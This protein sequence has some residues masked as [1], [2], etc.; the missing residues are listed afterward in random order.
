MQKKYNYKLSIIFLI[1][2][3]LC[4]IGLGIYYGSNKQN[5][6][7]DEVLTY[8]LSN[9]TGG[10]ALE[11]PEGEY[12]TP[13]VFDNMMNV[14][15]GEQ[16]HYESV[17]ENQ[18]NDVHPPLYY[19]IIHTVCSFFPETFSMWTGI[20]VN[21]FCAVIITL[22][23]FKIAE[24]FTR[25]TISAVLIAAAWACS[26][27]N[28][29]FIL[30]IRMYMLLIVWC[31]LFVLIHLKNYGEQRNWKFYA[32]LFIATLAGTL[33][34]YYFLIFIF[35]CCA[36]YC[37]SLL[38]KKQW[39]A[40]LCYGTVI[41][42]AGMTAVFIFHGVFKHI[43]MGQ[44]GE[45]SFRN[46][47]NLDNVVER[48]SWF[49]R[50]IN[51]QTFDGYI[52][53][54]VCVCIG[55]IIYCHVRRKDAEDRADKRFVWK[56]FLTSPT[57]LLCVPAIC[58]FFLVSQIAVYQVERYM[59]TI[60]PFIVL[61][62]GV[63]WHYAAVQL[64][65]GKTVAYLG[66]IILI[67]L[68]LHG[69]ATVKMEF[70]YVNDAERMEFARNNR[71]ENVIVVADNEQELPYYAYMEL[72]NYEQFLYIQADNLEIL[73]EKQLNEADSAI[74]YILADEKD[75]IEGE[76]ELLLENCDNHYQPFP[77]D[78]WIYE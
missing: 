78:V 65:N 9:S 23:V 59:I 77:S 56:Q 5:L 57:L 55:V 33:T 31:L 20:A 19:A 63:L 49:A 75:K 43:F 37:L 18:N 16:F 29:N 64:K 40:I 71:K 66:G 51:I 35:F 28:M 32:A 68:S 34:H 12:L 73:K 7:I 60:Y 45:E 70:R 10:I 17:W 41:A 13:A 21:L 36:V 62:I 46:F 14:N 58:Y 53:F 8:A 48:I 38:I 52:P 26:N 25:D 47:F 15:R 54:I 50:K 11:L 1:I 4:E 72:R 24:Y 39:K 44:R 42:G 69:L 27:A 30:F 22:L 3:C 67:L 2:L 76:L 61:S 74:V 6:H